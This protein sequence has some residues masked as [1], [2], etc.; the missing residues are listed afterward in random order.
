MTE[1][2]ALAPSDSSLTVDR[3]DTTA[4]SVPNCI[5]RRAVREDGSFE[6]DGYLAENLRRIALRLRERK[7]TE[8]SVTF[9]KNAP[10]A[11][12]PNERLAVNANAHQAT[13]SQPLV[14]YSSRAQDGRPVRSSTVMTLNYAIARLVVDY[15]DELD[16]DRD[17]GDYGDFVFDVDERS[18]ELA[19]YA[20]GSEPSEKYYCWFEFEQHEVK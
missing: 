10:A 20:P 18:V 14:A 2:Q 9:S 4:K 12:R 19:V 5:L 16:I 13:F 7:V 1:T 15:L 8:V 3:P 11:S 6:P 17:Q